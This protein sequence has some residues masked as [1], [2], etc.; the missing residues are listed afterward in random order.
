MTLGYHNIEVNFVLKV[1]FFLTFWPIILFVVIEPPLL[2]PSFLS[3]KFLGGEMDFLLQRRA[4]ERLK[5][6]LLVSELDDPDEEPDSC[7]TCSCG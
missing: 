7:W 2:L 3:V 6:E 1:T 5:L 4:T